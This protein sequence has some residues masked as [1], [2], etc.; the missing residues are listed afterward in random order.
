MS[1]SELVSFRT[2]EDEIYFQALDD[3]AED[4]YFDNFSDAVRE[5]ISGYLGDTDLPSEDFSLYV[6]ARAISETEEERREAL[7]DLFFY[8]A[9]DES[10]KNRDFDALEELSEVYMER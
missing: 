3:M 6:G 10:L 4:G 1:E 9:V 5:T 8:R 7:D 2:G